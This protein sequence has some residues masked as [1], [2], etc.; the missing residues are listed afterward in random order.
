[1]DTKHMNAYLILDLTIHD[2]PGFMEYVQR[3][4]DHI[5]KHQGRNFVEG[6]V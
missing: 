2:I 1:M 3:I 6:V 5:Q 4:P